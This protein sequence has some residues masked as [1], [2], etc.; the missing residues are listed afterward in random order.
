[1]HDTF[2]SGLVG[3]IAD[4]YRG[5]FFDEALGDAQTDALV[6]AGDGYDFAL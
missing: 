3:E 6:P 5:A 1:L 2:G 4:R